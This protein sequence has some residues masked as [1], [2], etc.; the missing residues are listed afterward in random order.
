MSIKNDRVK[1]ADHVGAPLTKEQI[2][3]IIRCKRDPI[4]FIKKYVFIQNP[5][6][7]AVKF[8]LYDYQENLVNVYST[9]DRVIAL[10]SRQC[11]KTETAGAFCLWWAIF[12]R[13][14][15]ILIASKDHDGAKDI[16]S[17]LWYAYEELPWW[18]KPGTK[19]NQV[20]TKEFDNGSRVI[21]TATTSTSGRGKANSL[22]YLDEFAFVRPGIANEFWTSIYPTISTGGRCIIT[23]TPNTDEDK[24]AQ[25]WF[26]AK[27]SNLSDP[28]KDQF[29]ERAKAVG[30]YDAEEPEVYDTLFES[31]TARLKYADTE[32]FTEDDQ[33]DEM[34]DG[35]VG[36]HAHWTRVPDGRGGFRDERFKRKTLMAGLS[37]EEWLREYECS[38]VSG[39]STLISATK[40]ATL[41]HVVRKPRFVDEDGTRWYE[42]VEPNQI[43]GVTLD[44]SEGVALDDACIQVWE[45]PA[46]KQVAEWNS[47]LVDQTGQ[48]KMLKKIL[49]RIFMIQQND[50]LHNGQVEIYYSVE[51]DGLG[52]G[53]LQ[54]IEYE[55][56]RTFPGYMIDSTMTSINARGQGMETKIANRWRGLITSVSTKKRY[57]TQFKDLVERNLFI[58]RS[59]QLASQLKTF[60][61][62]GQSWASKEGS[63]D[64]LVM[65]CV[66][67]CHL[68]DELRYHEPDLDDLIRPEILDGDYDPDDATHPDN[69]PFLPIV[70]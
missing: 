40:L 64:D 42:E 7:G 31:E 52:I 66:L 1:P 55:D 26:N 15:R 19:V 45:I 44:P 22:I 69:M 20:H 27:M 25:I 38:F 30:A 54:S 62:S 59:K 5:T 67:M 68:V 39:D 46:M 51:R 70:G 24:F 6:K 65:S 48:T 36:F 58:P 60:V 18:I 37:Q 23:S 43:Y 57:C 53:I 33:D 32:L 11:G 17:R 10:L 61:R 13:D 14:Q 2:Q 34:M 12:K 28:W 49:D 29:A 4:Y 3:E 63:K 47:N 41:R 21:A 35:F 8:E 56:E 9:Q 16:M 50:P